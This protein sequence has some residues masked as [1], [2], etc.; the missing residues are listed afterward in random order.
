MNSIVSRA[1]SLI[2]LSYMVSIAHSDDSRGYETIRFFNKRNEPET[3]LCYAASPNGQFLALSFD[4][5]F[6]GRS[7]VTIVDLKSKQ[8]V[9]ELGNFSCFTIAFSSDSRRMLGIDRFAVARVFDLSRESV[10]E[11]KKPMVIGKI[12]MD[13]EQK[14][15]KVS[16]PLLAH[17]LVSGGQ[18]DRLD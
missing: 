17:G 8:L 3:L 4:S 15:G 9:S 1:T 2:L 18:E 14:N 5:G 10:K 16:I 12:G 11:V 7:G 13:F 6:V